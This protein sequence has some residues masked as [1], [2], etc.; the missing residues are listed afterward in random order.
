MSTTKLAW[1]LA[2]AC[3]NFEE[4]QRGE[5]EEKGEE[6]KGEGRGKKH[7]VQ[8]MLLKENNVELNSKH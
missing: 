8:T 5:R 1:Q 6:T 7:S 2:N 3:A 4:L